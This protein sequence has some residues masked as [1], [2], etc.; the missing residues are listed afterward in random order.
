MYQQYLTVYSKMIQFPPP[1]DGSAPRLVPYDVIGHPQ[2]N[3]SFAVAFPFHPY[4][5]GR[6]GGEVTLVR[7]YAHGPDCMMY[8]LPAGAFEPQKHANLRECALSGQ[9]AAG[10]RN[11]G[12]CNHY[13]DFAVLGAASKC[14]G[15]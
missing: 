2:A 14:L 13:P 9:S 12:K 5:D 10:G 8:G 11:A 3:F 6:K 7:E 15:V 4:K 1:A